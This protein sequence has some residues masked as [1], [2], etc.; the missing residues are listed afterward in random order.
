MTKNIP[1]I[2]LHPT[3]DPLE[4]QM[5][6][7]FKSVYERNAFVL[8]AEVQSL[9]KAFARLCGVKEG[10]GVSSGTAALTLTLRALGIG[11]GDEVLTTPF[12]F[13]STASCIAYVGARPVF[14]DVE[15]DTL[16]LDPAKLEA[17]RTDKT[18][19]VLP[20]HLFGHPARMDAIRRFAQKHG[21]LIV[22]DAC[23]AH[24][25][26]YLDRS[27]GGW[28]D[29]ACFSF[30]PS[31]NLGGLG[32]G[33]LVVTDNAELA[34]RLRVLR[35]CGRRDVPYEHSELG[36]VERLDN[37]QAAFLLV[38][39]KFLGRWNAERKKL[40]RC[41]EEGLAGT[42]VHPLP[43]LPEAAPVY[44]LF[45]VRTPRRD[46]LQKYLTGQGIGTGICYKTPLHLQKAF[47][48]LKGRRGD[49]PVAE[50]AA[51]EVLS[52]PLYAGLSPAAVRRVCAEIRRFF[53]RSSNG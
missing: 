14:A 12:S 20:V 3:H 28:G 48:Y 44:H 8:G 47:A 32:D 33:G 34:G 21:L 16:N 23:Q 10:I 22:E 19:A 45:T 43:S 38:K 1:L 37:M 36:Y 42:P 2:D 15:E 31:K 6:A 40:V 27:V 18:K 9:E 7:A 17:L 25:A 26:K 11:P 39:L 46:D 53:S 13:F 5:V 52:L 29:A 49:F 41:Y 35:N 24:G 30:Y 50:K 51:E 4:K